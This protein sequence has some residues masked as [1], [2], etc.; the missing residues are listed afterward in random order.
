MSIKYGEITIIRDLKNESYR[1][2]FA[3]LFG[4]EP[5][6]SNNKTDKIILLFEDGNISEIEPDIKCNNIEFNPVLLSISSTVYPSHIKIKNPNKII[7]YKNP[8]TIDGVQKMSFNQIF[9]N[10]NCYKN[11]NKEGSCY[12]CIYYMHSYPDKKDVFSILRVK[13]NEEKPRYIIAYDETVLSFSD[14]SYLINCTFRNKFE[15]NK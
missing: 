7:F 4:Y 3:R 9:S 11:A 5:N 6:I 10:Y 12:N 14:L 2:Y 13:S 15:E 1:N 8:E